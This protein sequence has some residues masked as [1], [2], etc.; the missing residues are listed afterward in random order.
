MHY[1]ILL[2]NKMMFEYVYDRKQTQS[3]KKPAIHASEEQ[4]DG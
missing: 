2:L 1:N 3:L 4:A